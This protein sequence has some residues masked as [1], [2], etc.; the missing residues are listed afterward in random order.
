MADAFLGRLPL[1]TI[2]ECNIGHVDLAQMNDVHLSVVLPCTAWLHPLVGTSTKYTQR[3]L[4]SVF[5]SPA[6]SLRPSAKALQGT[7]DSACQ[8]GVSLLRDCCTHNVS[9]ADLAM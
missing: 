2:L 6:G 8:Q 9:V 7:S 4:S 3:A 1:F 5:T